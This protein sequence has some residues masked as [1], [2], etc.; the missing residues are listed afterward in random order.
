MPS[1][2][3]RPSASYRKLLRLLY[4][5]YNFHYLDSGFRL[6][7]FDLLA[8]EPGLERPLIAERLGL[9]DQ[10]TRILLNGCVGA[11]L[12][13]RE[14]DGYHLTPVSEPLTADF[15]DMAEAFLPYEREINYRAMAWFHE[16]LTRDTNVGMQREIPGSAPTLYGRLAADSDREAVFHRMMGRVTQRVAAALAEVPDFADYTHLL[17]VGGGT[18]VNA[19]NLVRRWPNLNVT[20]GDLPTVV[21]TGNARIAEAGLAERIRAVRLN[22][23]TDEFPVGA[24]CVLFS[25]FLEIWSPERIRA[26][27]AKAAR[28]VAPGAGIFIVTPGDEEESGPELA[29]G[30][31][32]Y[33]HCIASGEG[34]VYAASDFERWLIEAGFELTGRTHV[35]GLGDVMISGVKR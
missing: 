22:A 23:F 9:K 33:F 30:L 5:H 15:K 14:G 27:L 4:A 2:T 13:R 6:G 3:A 19:I 32:A 26:L 35:G 8:K 10:P 20:I 34:M 21:A 17:D 24:D 29:A 16:S 11:E 28:A 31:S 7:L 12:L 25:H 18:A 1:T